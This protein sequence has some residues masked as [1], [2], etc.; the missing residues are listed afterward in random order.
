[1]LGRLVSPYPFAV[2]E[3]LQYNAKLGY[4]PVG[5]ATIS[6]T[7]LA[8]ERGLEAFVFTMA[9][10]GGPP[11]WRVRYD[12]TSSVDSRRF[13]SLRFHRRL[14]QAGKV[15]EH[16]YVIVPDSARYRQAGKQGDWVAPREPLDELAFLYFLRTVRL[17]T[18]RSYSFDRYFMTGYNPIQVEVTGRESVALPDGAVPC[19]ALRVTTRGVATR[20]W[21]TD[22]ARRLPAQLE[23]PLQFGAVTLV[24][25]GKRGSGE[26]GK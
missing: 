24:L 17:E 12:L 2:G 15:E 8:R 16:E 13:N 14:E 25:A 6:V 5:T 21:L 26:A 3:T 22:D 7:R 4:F 23:V 1:M 19:L 20:V 9:G 18:G 10:Q 11:G